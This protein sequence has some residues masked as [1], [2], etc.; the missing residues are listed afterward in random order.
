MIY[1]QY[2]KQVV[3]TK[4][5]L[6]AHSIN[7][8]AVLYLKAALFLEK[9]DTKNNLKPLQKSSSKAAKIE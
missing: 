2:L 1:L 4:L 8:K 9:G 6:Y 5:G 3:P 7:T